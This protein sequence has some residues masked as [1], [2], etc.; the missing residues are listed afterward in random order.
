MEISELSNKQIAILWFGLE[1]KSSLNFLLKNNINPWNITI[2]DRQEIVN[3]PKWIK[4]INWKNYL[5]NISQYDIILKT[6]WS[7]IY[8]NQE[9]IPVKSRITTQ[10]QL[11]FD[12]YKWKI[13]WV[14]ASKWKSTIS[15]L[16]YKVIKDAGKNVKFVWNIWIPVLDEINFKQN[17]DYVVCEIS[18]YMLEFLNKKNH[19]S[20]LWSIFP[21]HLDWHNGFE[22][23]VNAKLKILQWSEINIICNKT[24]KEYNLEKQ[25]KNIISYWKGWSYWFKNWFFT[26]DWNSIFP[27]KNIKL[28]WNH[29]LENICAVFATIDQLWIDIKSVEKTVTNFTGLP[30]RLEFVWIYNSIEFYDDAI[31]TTPE[32]TI[33][34]I[35][36]LNKKID[37]IFLWW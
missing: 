7:S 12:N 29:N 9:L 24:L 17:Y 31:S 30:H 13:I 15:T 37:T 18:S 25:Y 22:N 34:A 35:K 23:Y 36:T 20:I 1:W 16:L 10:M 6:A 4:S 28:L 19:I 27:T 21:E 3:I 8:L 26:K 14:T 2:L 32:S 11:F 33:Q 5:E